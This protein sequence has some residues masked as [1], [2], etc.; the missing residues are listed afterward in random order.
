M[1]GS[2]KMTK[3]LAFAGVLEIVGHVEVGVHACLEDGNAAQF[4]ELR[5]VGVVVE[6]TGDQDVESP[7]RRLRGRPAPDRGRQTVPNSGPMKT[8]ARLRGLDAALPSTKVP[9]AQTRSPGQG[10]RAEK[11]IRS[12]CAPVERRRF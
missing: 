9:S 1:S 12:L 11:E 2:P 5:G 3:R 8:P 7:R 6:G 4:A 10:L